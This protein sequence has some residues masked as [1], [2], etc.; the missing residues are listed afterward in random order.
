M[1]ASSIVIGTANT[2][3]EAR[4]ISLDELIDEVYHKLR[5]RLNDGKS[6]PAAPFTQIAVSGQDG[7][8]R[9]KDRLEEAF[10]LPVTL[11]INLFANTISAMPVFD[12]DAEVTATSTTNDSPAISTNKT[13][14][15]RPQNAFILYRKDWHS[16]VVAENPHLHNNQ[17]SKIIGEKWRNEASA[18]KDEYKKRAELVKKQHA[19]LHPDYSYQ[20]RKPCERKK[21]M[22]KNKLARLQAEGAIVAPKLTVNTNTRYAMFDAGPEVNDGL[23]HQFQDAE[24]WPVNRYVTSANTN[25]AQ[26]QPPVDL[27]L[28]PVDTVWNMVGGSRAMDMTSFAIKDCE[29][30]HKMVVVDTSNATACADLI[31]SHMSAHPGQENISLADVVSAPCGTDGFENEAMRQDDYQQEMSNFF[32][33]D[34]A[35]GHSSATAVDH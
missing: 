3:F 17:I 15:A 6:E 30:M 14:I 11:E 25:A 23:L 28:P 7:L 18:V 9:L 24:L 27:M 32:D 26:P 16:V 2:R 19:V 31:D 1:A 12:S 21:R 29:P 35:S 5:N 33:F 4:R 34:F 8:K 22:T 20:P 10:D 13:K